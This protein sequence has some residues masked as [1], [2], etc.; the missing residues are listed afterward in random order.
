MKKNIRLLDCTLRD[1][2]HLNEGNFGEDTIRRIIQHLIDAQIDIIEL[3]FLWNKSYD[4]NVTRFQSLKDIKRILPKDYG[5]SKISVMTDYNNLQHLETNDGSIHYIRV[6]FKRH[7]IDWALD[8]VCMLQNKGY[9]CFMNPVNCNVYT[10]EEYL[11]L[12]KRVNEVK[13]YGFSI[14][15]TF[16]VMRVE[17]L[18]ARYYLVENNLNQ[19]IVIGLHLHENLGLSYAMAQKYIEVANPL[20]EHTL[21]GSLLGMGRDPGNL[22]IEQIANYINEKYGEYYNM[23]AL[24]DAIDD[25]M[26]RLLTKYHWGYSIPY[27]LSGKYRIHRT[28]AETLMNMPHLSLSDMD[29]IMKSID[30]SKAELFDKEYLEELCKKYIE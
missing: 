28:Y 29:N 26:A 8:T 16:G 12:I 15:D 21:D 4:E 5:Q 19:D 3:G 7:L 23:H 14:V 24:Y 6:I 9:P 10:D 17:D 22:H 30:V 1:G 27:A 18:I 13:P 25:D 2:G 11:M 20:R